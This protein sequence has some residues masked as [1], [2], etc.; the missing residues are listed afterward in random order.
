MNDNKV[1]YGIMG[2][3]VAGVIGFLV[4][5][6]KPEALERVGSEQENQGR[7]H[8]EQGESVAYDDALPP[9]SGS[10]GAPIGWGD[11]PTPVPEE[12]VVH[13]L[14]H[15]GI[16]ISYNPDLVSEEDL[17]QLRGLFFKPYSNSA[18]APTKVVMAPRPENEAAIVFS[19]WD[20]NQLFDS[21]NKEDMTAY[22]KTNVNKSPELAG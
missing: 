13:D 9:T 11:Y 5:A 1:F 10:H 21:F 14:E 15:G 16:Y 2:L 22:Y 6:P 20:R 19:S 18:F 7:K 4:L 12:N 8:L 17:Q 3:L